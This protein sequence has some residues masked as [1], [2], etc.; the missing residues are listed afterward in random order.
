MSYTRQ[1]VFLHVTPHADAVLPTPAWIIQLFSNGSVTADKYRDLLRTPIAFEHPVIK[2]KSH[3]SLK[4]CS[5]FILYKVYDAWTTCLQETLAEVMSLTESE[6]QPVDHAHSTELQSQIMSFMQYI[7]PLK[8]ELL[9]HLSTDEVPEHFVLQMEMY[10]C[11]YNNIVL[12]QREVH[13]RYAVVV[14]KNVQLS[15]L[16]QRNEYP[17]AH[18]LKPGE[19]LMDGSAITVVNNM[20]VSDAMVQ[21][22]NNV[23]NETTVYYLMYLK[24]ELL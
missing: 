11:L 9:N 21:I 16:H 2:S 13:D 19:L 5:L 17:M 15:V 18:S 6:H 20:K 23:T 22:C 7:Q 14:D 8:S 3:I 1:P 4:K 24:Y 10:D 12:D